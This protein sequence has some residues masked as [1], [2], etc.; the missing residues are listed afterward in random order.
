MREIMQ[1]TGA[2]IQAG[3]IVPGLGFFGG[4]FRDPFRDHHP[5]NQANTCAEPP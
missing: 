1:R 3:F 4:S 5:L 2:E